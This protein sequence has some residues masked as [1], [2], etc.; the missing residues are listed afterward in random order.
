MR[1]LAASCRLYP[2]RANVHLLKHRAWWRKTL[3]RRSLWAGLGLLLTA[4]LV[5]RLAEAGFKAGRLFQPDDLRDE[6]ATLDSFSEPAVAC[7]ILKQEAERLLLVYREDRDREQPARQPDTG[8]GVEPEPQAGA[9]RIAEPPAGSRILS[10]PRT[11]AIQPL[12]VLD[13]QVR[14]LKLSLCR[15]L[16]S[17]YFDQHLWNE[18]VDRYL[19]LVREGPEQPEVVGYVF[20]ALECS[21]KCG[22]AEEVVDVLQHVVRFHPESKRA[23]ELKRALEKW[24]TEGAAVLEVGQR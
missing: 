21:Q 19:Q 23:E 14:D 6:P 24:K 18:F 4:L 11:S 17:V 2:V 20:C 16:L 12:S 5:G 1:S 13:A 7:A 10:R 22:R 3:T 8:R 9:G 15:E